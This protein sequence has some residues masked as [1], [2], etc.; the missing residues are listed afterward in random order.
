M[1]LA[2]AEAQKAGRLDDALAQFAVIL[3]R[4]PS[5]HEAMYMAGMAEA[6]KGRFAPAAER[7]TSALHADP[8][9]PEYLFR[10]GS[11]LLAL[12]RPE[13][14]AE[15]LEEAA[16]EADD[17]APLFIELGRARLRLRE[18]PAAET[19]LRRALGLDPASTIAWRLLVSA[20]IPQRGTT[21]KIREACD[22]LAAL[23]PAS[24]DPH[25][26]L[27]SA[28]E[29]D[30]DTA[31]AREAVA[32]ALALDAAC[33]SALLTL[34]ELERR[35]GRPDASRAALE[36]A[37]SAPIEP[38]LR[39]AACHSLATL[40]D[41]GGTEP[42]RAMRLFL[43]A[44]RPASEVPRAFRAQ[45]ESFLRFVEAARRDL[46]KDAIAAWP[47]PPPADRPS[48]VFFVGFPRSG[49]TLLEQMLGSHPR[50]LPTDE[51]GA[52]GLARETIARWSGGPERVPL[53]LAS[54]AAPQVR[55][56][57][58]G[59][60]D[61]LRRHLSIDAFDDRRVL[62]KHPMNTPSLCVARRLFPDAKVIMSIRDPRDVCLSCFMTFSSSPL[63]AVYF[64]TVEA[65]ARVYA[66]IMDL[67]LRDRDALGL[68]VLEVRYEGLVADPEGAVRRVLGFLG[69]P[70]HDSVLAYAQ[71][72][73]R[74]QVR[75]AS[76]EQVTREI[77][78]D[79]I[80]RWTRYRPFLGDAEA[81]LRPF[82]ER[83]GYPADA[84]AC[85]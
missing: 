25:A 45:A 22:R 17:A 33:P 64:P 20:L 27:A 61:D 49:T 46:T 40:L 44:K 13:D 63:G 69:E 66:T 15:R 4:W 70:W 19:A 9:N 48:P 67:W 56:L 53:A 54:L 73:R 12:D 55:T 76:Y 43:D 83:L 35:D 10:L 26:L 42:E 36:R 72:A 11:A 74:T 38:S 8:G 1:F 16:K 58:A 80:G 82:V 77:Y 7:F 2:A 62:D 84:D 50:F 75:T 41:R 31:G 3:T 37:L 71:R 59:Y 21:A 85:A 78:R 24:P 30:N 65:A 34:A 32:R 39:R 52:L 47:A 81:I 23:E 14:A 28:L 6:A 18:Y 5:C 29:R 60:W 51:P 79:S 57:R 68:D